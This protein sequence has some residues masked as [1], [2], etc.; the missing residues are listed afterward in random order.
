MFGLLDL[1]STMGC[2]DD[3]MIGEELCKLHM[4]IRRCQIQRG[5]PI[6]VQDCCVGS[7]FDEEL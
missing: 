5:Q 1:R 6:I 2:P 7:M 4:S 3:A